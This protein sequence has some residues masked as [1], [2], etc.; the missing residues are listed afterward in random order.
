MDK[1]EKKLQALNKTIKMGRINFA[2]IMTLILMAPNALIYLQHG[3][4]LAWLVRDTWYYFPLLFF[5]FYM[6]W[7]RSLR[8]AKG[9]ATEMGKP[10]IVTPPKATGEEK[11]MLTIV[12]LIMVAPHFLLL[13]A[14]QWLEKK[15]DD[16]QVL[17]VTNDTGQETRLF[18]PSP[19]FNGRKQTLR[20]ILILGGEEQ[21]SIYASINNMQPAFP[22]FSSENRAVDKSDIMIIQFADRQSNFYIQNYDH[23]YKDLRPV[24]PLLFS[25]KKKSDIQFSYVPPEAL[26]EGGEAI[27]SD[28]YFGIPTDA[29]LKHMRVICAKPVCVL[30]TSIDP[31]GDTHVVFFSDNKDRW[32]EIYRKANTLISNFAKPP[33]G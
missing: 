16:T 5:G 7:L 27:K 12:T 20:N 14:L 21:K 10:E 31:T 19:Y 6:V 25:D 15:L 26:G 17:H 8:A 4:L 11:L 13:P 29:A 18:V 9:I 30:I 1:Q 23:L 28:V 2:M 32:L 22:S 33:H 24:S 3:G